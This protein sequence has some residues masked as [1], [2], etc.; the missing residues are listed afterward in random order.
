MKRIISLILIL[1][2]AISCTSNKPNQELEKSYT[3][4]HL[5]NTGDTLSVYHPIVITNSTNRT[6]LRFPNHQEISLTGGIIIVN[7]HFQP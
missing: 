5:T 3:V 1:I 4:I 2:L 7:K 6:Y